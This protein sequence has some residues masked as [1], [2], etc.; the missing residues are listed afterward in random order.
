MTETSCHARFLME[1]AA[2]NPLSCMCS[3]INSCEMHFVHYKFTVNKQFFLAIPS[4]CCTQRRQR[5]SP[6]SS[7]TQQ[8]AILSK[9]VP[10]PELSCKCAMTG[11]FV[12]RSSMRGIS[13]RVLE[14]VML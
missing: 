13:N 9:N 11:T 7:R 4:P 14:S 8:F 10:T 3:K 5:F 1:N 6:D 12:M 2:K